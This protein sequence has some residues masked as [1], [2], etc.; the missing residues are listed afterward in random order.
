MTL[1]LM[2]RDNGFYYAVVDRTRWISLR[3][4]NDKE[5]R[6]IFEEIKV[7]YL[8]GKLK[9]INPGKKVT[10]GSFVSEYLEHRQHLSDSTLKMD[11][12]SLRLFAD[13]V[14]GNALLVN[15]TRAD[16]D[17]FKNICVARRCENKTGT[18]S[19]RSVN[20]YLRHLRAAFSIAHDWK[21]I[22]EKLEF[23]MLRV[24][25][26]LPRVL[27][28]SE[29]SA[30]LAKAQE[31]NPEAWLLMLFYLWTGA[32]R[33]EAL[34]LKWSDVTLGASATCKLTG[35]GN[36]E[37]VVPLLPPILEAL[38]PPP[39]EGGN[40]FPRR[41]PSTV[42]HWFQDIAKSAGIKARL[43][44]LRH[45]AA[46]YMLA[47]GIDLRF[48]QEILGHSQLST[49]TIYTHVIPGRLH[50]EMSKLKFN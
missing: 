48:V 23:K 5:A 6:P 25:K 43:H 4:K 30:L 50:G 39:D 34:S 26:P 9:K 44:D 11:Q 32:R 16:I 13:V 1:R 47:N 8:A 7:K 29:I 49:T 42:S 14:G 38:G 35:K 2:R 40:V 24:G 27:L 46:T 10:F 28:P 37:R 21:Y 36:K 12:L 3:T 33:K 15:I 31:Q 45:T 41:N 19:K 22:D 20:S 17:R 18:L